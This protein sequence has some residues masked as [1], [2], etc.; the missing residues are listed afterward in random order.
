MQFTAF[1]IVIVGLL[2]TSNAVSAAPPQPVKANVVIDP[3]VVHLG[4]TVT[5]RCMAVS[6]GNAYPLV[7]VSAGYPGKVIEVQIIHS[8]FEQN[9]PHILE[10]SFL[11][12]RSGDVFCR[13]NVVVE[14]VLFIT[15]DV[16]ALEV[17]P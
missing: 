14:G 6:L 2:V 7:Q 10:I 5:F 13:A 16:A 9:G 11:A 15:E 8:S 12:E 4:D 17:L 1:L 3:P